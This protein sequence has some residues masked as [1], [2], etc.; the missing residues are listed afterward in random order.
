M[1]CIDLN[2]VRNEK[3]Y[4]IEQITKYRLIDVLEKVM[5]KDNFSENESYKVR[6]LYFDTIYNKDY[7]EKKSGIEK[8]RKIRLRTYNEN[9]DLVK[10][11]IKEKINEVQ[12]KES[13]LI[14]KNA[15]LK[16]INGDYDVLRLIKSPIAKKIQ[17]IMQLE[18][19]KPTCIIEYERTAFVL[20][21]NDTRITI[22][23]NIRSTESNFDLFSKE[24]MLNKVVEDVVLEVKY[25]RFLVS[26]IKDILDSVNKLDTSCSKY[27]MGR[28]L[29]WI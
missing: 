23:E 25:D 29:E 9:E 7:I 1:V 12:R 3:K 11:E 2:I 14:K 16:L 27:C 17:Y 13:I 5:K 21:E 15:A 26:Y 4:R 10:L 28:V 19:Y 20:E 24:L 8:R 18:L 22:D 6:S